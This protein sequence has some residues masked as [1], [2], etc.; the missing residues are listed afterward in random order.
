VPS[1]ADNIFD[2]V[3]IA[4]GWPV[5][6]ASAKSGDVD[7]CRVRWVGNHAMAPFEVVPADALRGLAARRRGRRLLA[8]AGNHEGR[9]GRTAVEIKSR[10]FTELES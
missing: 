7:P 1:L 10:Q 6:D 3:G 9:S 5:P 4:G 2:C 8:E